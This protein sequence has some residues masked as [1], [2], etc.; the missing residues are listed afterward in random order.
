MGGRD[1]FTRRAV[2]A[3]R[4]RSRR[5]RHAPLRSELAAFEPRLGARGHTNATASTYRSRWPQPLR[6]QYP[7][8]GRRRSHPRNIASRRTGLVAVGRG[9]G[10][11][12]WRTAA[13]PWEAAVPSAAPTAW[14][15]ASNVAYRPSTEASPSSTAAR[16]RSRGHQARLSLWASAPRSATRP[17]RRS[18]SLGTA[19]T[20]LYRTRPAAVG[21]LSATQRMQRYSM[22]A[23]RT[24]RPTQALETSVRRH[25]VAQVAYL[26]LHAQRR[27]G[28]SLF[29]SGERAR[30]PSSCAVLRTTSQ[31][32]ERC[33]AVREAP[34]RQRNPI[35]VALTTTGCRL[36]HVRAARESS[37]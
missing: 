8:G 26:L 33:S 23:S 13:E 32:V 15:S 3:G 7:R 6:R 36:T 14:S 11:L 4:R 22:I 37:R 35:A 5:N 28:R 16:R 9:L 31:S 10:A 30:A 21:R 12:L 2:G 1:A 18:A 29:I 17:P 25:R 27:I 19:R 20:R 34:P 24:G